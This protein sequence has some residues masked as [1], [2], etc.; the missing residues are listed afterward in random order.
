MHKIK[1]TALNILSQIICLIGRK[2]GRR[3]TKNLGL[4]LKLHKFLGMESREHTKST[5]MGLHRTLLPCRKEKNFRNLYNP[6]GPV[7]TE[8]K[9]GQ[10]ISMVG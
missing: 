10:R 8:T 1:F 5:G 6:A 4:V 3:V 7:K 2:N 9:R